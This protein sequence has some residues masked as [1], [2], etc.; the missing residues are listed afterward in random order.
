MTLTEALRRATEK[1]N[2]QKI[3]SASLD[4]E[5][6]LSLALKKN[7]EFLYTHPEK[8][9]SL[10][11]KLKFGYL[12]GRRLKNVPLAYLTGRKEFYG[13]DFLVNRN[14]LIPRPL[15]EKIVELALKEIQP[16][17]T[18]VDVGTGSG[19]ILISVAL[20]LKKK[21]ALTEFR[22]YGLDISAK[23]L[24]VAKQNARIH[25]VEKQITFLESNL[26][27][28][29]KNHKIDLILAN[30]PYLEASDL[31][32]PSIQKE[33]RLALVGNYAELF[34]QI[35]NLQPKPMVIYEDKGGVRKKEASVE[36]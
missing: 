14:V 7:K 4:A 11:A 36:K 23:A 16:G 2:R 34:R 13:Y 28:K 21:Y 31:N 8:K 22:F 1:L 12:I 33:P 19:N 32:E 27:E 3:N 24:K 26:L 35:L 30:L 5:L 9:L 6:L 10:F 25:K 20:E 29:V 18:V 17:F 15:S